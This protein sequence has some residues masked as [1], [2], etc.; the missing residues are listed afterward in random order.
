MGNNNMGMGMGMN[1]PFSNQPSIPDYYPQPDVSSGCGSSGGCGSRP[2]VSSGCGSPMGCGSRPPYYPPQPPMQQPPVSVDPVDE[3]VSAPEQSVM[4]LQPFRNQQMM[5]FTRSYS[6]IQGTNCMNSCRTRP[7]YNARPICRPVCNQRPRC[8]TTRPQVDYQQVGQT[9]FCKPRRSRCLTN[10][11]GWGN[12]GGWGGSSWGGSNWGGSGYNPGGN[13]GSGYNP[14]NNE[15]F[16]PGDVS[17]GSGYN[18][19]GNEGFNPGYNSGYQQMPMYNQMPMQPSYPPPMQY[20]P[21]GCGSMGCGN[22]PVY[23]AGEAV[24]LPGS[25]QP[26]AA[27]GMPDQTNLDSSDDEN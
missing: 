11:C 3:S 7:Q 20:Q 24:T 15:G 12:S 14:G 18:P 10:T 26:P 19:G 22:R 16:N 2:P 8:R 1:M 9:T 21:S 4:P 17:G 23:G 13:G 5:P 25:V 6:P 27:P